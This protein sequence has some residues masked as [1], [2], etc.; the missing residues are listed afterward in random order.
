MGYRHDILIEMTARAYEILIEQLRTLKQ[1]D[2]NTVDEI[3]ANSTVTKCDTPAYN[4]DQPN[5]ICICFEWVGW[6]SSIPYTKF[7]YDFMK[8]IA[9]LH[10]NDDTP[11]AG[12]L[13][14]HFLRI[15]EDMDDLEE[16]VYGEYI[17]E[18]VH[19]ERRFYHDMEP[20]IEY[21]HICL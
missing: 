20:L 5:H 9:K 16:E 17:D 8:R 19:I 1:T 18:M 7:F 3:I 10:E 21:A 6:D 4:N 12:Q 14:V 2:P 15:G 11:D 13:G